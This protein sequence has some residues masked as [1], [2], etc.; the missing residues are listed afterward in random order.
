MASG[1]GNPNVQLLTKMWE[2][3]RDNELCVTI[4]RWAEESKVFVQHE[5]S[6]DMV[7]FIVRGP[8]V[9]YQQFYYGDAQTGQ[10]TEKL[11]AEIGL[12]IRMLNA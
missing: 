10:P 4:M 11:V 3:W 1:A 9:G 12:A 2:N 8:G 6:T 5:I 7:Y